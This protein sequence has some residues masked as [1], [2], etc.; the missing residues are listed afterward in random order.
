MN[1][2]A[3]LQRLQAHRKG[4]GEFVLV[5]NNTEPGRKIA[6]GSQELGKCI[7]AIDD[8]ISALGND[9]P[10]ARALRIATVDVLCSL[11]KLLHG[12]SSY[13]E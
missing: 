8:C 1:D 4:I 6:L 2:V 5:V 12:L 11:Q 10:Q 13:H 3:L 7:P 9:G